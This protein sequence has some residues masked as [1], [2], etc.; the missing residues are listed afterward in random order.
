MFIAGLREGT[1]DQLTYVYIF[2][3]TQSLI[4]YLLNGA[5]EG[6]FR[7]GFELIDVKKTPDG[8]GYAI[9]FGH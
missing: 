8:Y 3:N 9:E 4:S 6:V 7:Y 5:Q 2:Q 1:P